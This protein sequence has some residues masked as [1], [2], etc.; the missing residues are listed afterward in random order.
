MPA[1]AR[2]APVR[3]LLLFNSIMMVTNICQGTENRSEQHWQESDV[4]CLHAPGRRAIRVTDDTVTVLVTVTV[5]TAHRDNGCFPD[6]GRVDAGRL[7]W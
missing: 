2:G 6:A 1:R 3:Y 5:T 7:N 4:L